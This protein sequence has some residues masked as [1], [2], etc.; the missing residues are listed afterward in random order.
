M[1]IEF[2]IPC[3]VH[4][5]QSVRQGRGVY[6]TP[7]AIKA[8]A[9]ALAYYAMQHRPSEPFVGP[10][11]AEYTIE[12]VDHSKAKR[13]R[14]APYWKPTAP[15]CDNLAKQLSDVLQQGGFFTNDAQIVELCVRKLW[16][17]R[18]CV[19]VVLEEAGDLADA[20]NELEPEV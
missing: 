6:Y 20:L 14:K 7:A 18:C 8:N 5:K 3:R 12:C 19:V 4:P 9:A 13:G 15:D 1:R 17:D 10:I 2:T 11:R 16:S